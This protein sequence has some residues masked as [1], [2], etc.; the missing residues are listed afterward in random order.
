MYYDLEYITF[1]LVYSFWV[2]Y[3]LA[4]HATLVPLLFK[5]NFYIQKKKKPWGTP[6]DTLA[7][8]EETPS[9]TTLI[10]LSAR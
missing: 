8:S 3:L 10:F 9:T 1:K 5:Q 7:H 6:I 4:I 2:H